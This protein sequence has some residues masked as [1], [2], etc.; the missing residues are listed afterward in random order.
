MLPFTASALS[1]LACKVPGNDGK[2]V[3]AY[4]VQEGAVA[5]H[6]GRV[7][8]RISDFSPLADGLRSFGNHDE[9]AGYAIH[10]WFLKREGQYLPHRVYIP[11]A[12]LPNLYKPLKTW[13]SC[14]KKPKT[15]DEKE[16]AETFVPLLQL[17]FSRHPGARHFLIN[18]EAEGSDQL[19]ALEMWLNV[20]I[21]DLQ[22]YADREFAYNAVELCDAL[23]LFAR[24]KAEEGYLLIEFS[25]DPD[26]PI[27]LSAHYKGHDLLAGLP[28][29][30]E[31]PK[32]AK[33][34]QDA[35][36]DDEPEDD[37][38]PEFEELTASDKIVRL[39]VVS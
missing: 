31:K 17:S 37:T 36:A 8:W 13:L 29:V 22:A 38:D 14:R 23:S 2:D 4:E 7:I 27:W 30:R 39:E 1:T 6:T 9:L 25:Q 16:H 10:P 26:E 5:I 28:F 35:D 15:K 3:K 32:S 34:D 20:E 21:T 24:L 11:L 12:L 18:L 19:P 33:P